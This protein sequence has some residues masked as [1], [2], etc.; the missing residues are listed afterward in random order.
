METKKYNIG[1]LRKILIEASSE[2]KPVM[3]KNVEKDNKNI[4]DEAYKEM[5]KATKDYDGGKKNESNKKPTYP[6]TDNKGMQDLE[7]DQIN[8]DFKDRVK[9]QMKGYVSKDA[10]DKHKK[11]PYGNAE[12]NEIE[13]M[14]DRAKAF[15]QAEVNAKAMGL[16]S[17]E[18]DKKEFEKLSSNVFEDKKMPRL[19]FKNTAFV[20]EEHML[21]KVPDDFRVD[22]KKFIMKDKNDSE[23]VVEWGKDPKILNKKKIN[24]QKNRVQELFNYKR[25]N[26]NTTCESRLNEDKQISDMLGKARSL[27]K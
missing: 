4:N 14:E 5:T 10:E 25:M 22:G 6:M 11:D 1:E 12:F 24:E 3:G 9:S 16:T 7:Y 15:K 23:Y 26:S 17:R 18:L 8:D 20:N 2:F 21:S 19:R 13:G 27:M